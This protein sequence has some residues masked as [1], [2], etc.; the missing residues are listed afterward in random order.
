MTISIHIWPFYVDVV[1]ASSQANSGV[2]KSLK[3]NNNNNYK[4]NIRLH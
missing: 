1:H 4:L 3:L 2:A